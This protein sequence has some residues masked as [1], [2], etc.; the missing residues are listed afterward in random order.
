VIFQ[1]VSSPFHPLA[2]GNAAS[3]VLVV[4]GTGVMVNNKSMN[5]I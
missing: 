2:T 5:Q 3:G 1:G 4:R